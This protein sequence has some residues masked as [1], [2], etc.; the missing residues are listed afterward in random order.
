[1]RSKHLIIASID[2]VY[3][4]VEDAILMLKLET[5]LATGSL[6]PSFIDIVAGRSK[7]SDIEKQLFYGMHEPK[8][9]VIVLLDNGRRQIL[10]E[11][12]HFSDLFNCI[13]CGNCLLDCPAYNAVGPSFGADGMLGGRG[14]AVSCL[15]HGMR[16][17]VEDGLYLCTACGLCGEVCP[18]GALYRLCGNDHGERNDWLCHRTSSSIGDRF[19]IDRRG[20]LRS[21]KR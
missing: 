15:L 17:G 20:L 9:L 18:F 1:M 7:S 14:V 10:D 5:Y 12:K 3:P 11:H 4:N 21:C 8:E 19:Y 2:K 16:K 6:F 13:G